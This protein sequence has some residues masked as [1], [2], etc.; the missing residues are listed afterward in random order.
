MT[1]HEELAARY[2]ALADQP[3]APDNYAGADCRYSAGYEALERLF[4]GSALLQAG[5]PV[6]WPQVR[7]ACEQLLSLCSKDLRVATWLTWSLLHL[8]ALPGLLCGLNLL[9]ALCRDHWP[10]LYPR[11]PRARAAAFNWLLPRLQQAALEPAAAP[12]QSAL[13]DTLAELAALLV[14]QLGDD[15]P[16]LDPLR[17]RIADWRSAQRSPTPAETPTVPAPTTLPA[18]GPANDKDARQQ[19]RQ[20]QEQ[21]RLL[22]SYWL[23]HNPGDLRA[24]RLSRALAWLTLDGL[25]ASDASARTELRGPPADKREAYRERLQQGA[26]PALLAELEAS[27]IRCPF[28]LDGHH[29]AWQC[30]HALG[31]TAATREIE[32]QLALLLNRLP[33]LDALRFHDG[34]PFAEADTR[35]WIASR[36]CPAPPSPARGTPAGWQSA[37]H[38]G[39][40]LLAEHGLKSAVR[41]VGQGMTGARGGRQRFFWQLTLARLCFEAG[42][43]DVARPLLESLD[44]QLL[45]CG[46]VD[47]DPDLALEVLHLLRSCCQQLNRQDAREQQD[48]LQRRLCHLDLEAALD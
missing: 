29:L 18:S 7:D 10:L 35:A 42:R 13:H 45:S 46:L 43:H 12:L 22:C 4:D 48:D 34:S 39:R 14:R 44:R 3:I 15:A 32:Q 1:R 24:L 2:A 16:D 38:R 33:G 40:E 28:W 20:L 9:L 27:L 21:A 31:L 23:T 17:Q 37:L 11:K 36:I 19:L 41:Q 26:T 25:P 6:D 30:L 8:E 47:W 5:Q